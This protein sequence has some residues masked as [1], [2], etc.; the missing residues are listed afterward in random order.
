MRKAFKFRLYPNKEQEQKLFWTLA[1]CRELYNAALSERKDSYQVHQRMT[2]S[3]NQETGQVVAAM[4]VAPQKV[5]SVTYLQQKR[6]LPDIKVRRVEYQDIH[7]QVLQDV[8]LRLERA[9]KNFF[10]RIANGQTPGFP[11]FQ[12]RDRYNS[13][14]Y[15]QGGYSLT[16]DNRVCLSTIGSIKVKL[17]RPIE[18][19][20]KTCTIKYEAGGLVR[21][22]L[23]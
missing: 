16:H 22:L 18:G 2:V 1:R 21:C 6:D 7:S 11:R 10:R 14:T 20:S 5:T 19:T 3:Q 12:G 9:F 17:H 4:M 13:F 15:P 23:M 8:L